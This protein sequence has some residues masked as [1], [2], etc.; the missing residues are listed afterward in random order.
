MNQSGQTRLLGNTLSW[1]AI[2]FT[3]LTAELFVLF[4]SFSVVEDKDLATVSVATTLA[5]VLRDLLFVTGDFTGDFVSFA[6]DF[7]LFFGEVL[8]ETDS[9]AL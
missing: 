3:D 6:S 8:A 4:G 7:S 2:F 1:S 5:V 9:S